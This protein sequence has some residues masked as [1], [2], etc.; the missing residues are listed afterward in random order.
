[1][2]CRLTPFSGLDTHTPFFYL[3]RPRLA[4]PPFH[5]FYSRRPSLPPYPPSGFCFLEYDDSRDAKD[6]VADMDGRR[7]MDATIRVEISRSAGPRA[8]GSRD[9]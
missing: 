1:V 6:A 9:E 4:T 8:R 7:F 3:A 2:P 5:N